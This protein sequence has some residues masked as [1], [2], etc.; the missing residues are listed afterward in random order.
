M[1]VDEVV[2][3]VDLERQI[4]RLVERGATLE[5]SFENEFTLAVPTNGGYE[6]V[7]ES[8]C[9]YASDAA[10]TPELYYLAARS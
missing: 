3:S 9:F 2:R 4:A 7:D 8:L 10:R 6:P 1:D 5:A